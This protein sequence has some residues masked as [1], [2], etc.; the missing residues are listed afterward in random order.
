MSQIFLWGSPQI[1]SSAIFSRIIQFSQITSLSSLAYCTKSWAFSQNLQ[2]RSAS[3][4]QCPLC[5][6]SSFIIHYSAQFLLLHSFL[7][8]CGMRFVLC[9]LSILRWL[10][11]ER[12]ETSMPTF[13]NPFLNFTIHVS[14]YITLK[15]EGISWCVSYTGMLRLNQC[16]CIYEDE[17]LV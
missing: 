7:S 6:P 16:E 13:L 15:M 5:R 3:S 4:C 9:L 10:L 14:S 11:R 8:S 17:I 2:V 12:G 1:S